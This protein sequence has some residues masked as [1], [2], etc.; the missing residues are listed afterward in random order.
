LLAGTLGAGVGAAACYG[1]IFQGLLKAPGQLDEALR[2]AGESSAAGHAEGLL[3][4]AKALALKG[5]W[6]EGLQA[7]AAAAHRAGGLTAGYADDLRYLVANHPLFNRPEPAG[8][9]D[10]GAAQRY[11]NHGVKRYRAED[12]A[13]AEQAFARAVRCYEADAR[14]WYYLGLARLA[15][16]KDHVAVDAFRQG[17]RRERQNLP[18]SAD[19]VRSL[20]RVQGEARQTLNRYRRR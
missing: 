1:A 20:E 7:F 2:L 15:Q 4:K 14:Y 16:G 3:L 6:T 13:A 19:V 12:H 10:R 11:Y 8:P 9:P 18:H 5:Q 17:A